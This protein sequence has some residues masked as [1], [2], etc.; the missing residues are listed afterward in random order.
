MR[1]RAAT[2]ADAAVIAAA[3]REIARVPG[4]LASRPEEITDG[5][6]A[7][8]I[9][10]V[11]KF[12][13]AERDGVI[14]GHAF[15]EPLQLAVTA[16]VVRL[17]IAV[18]PGFERQGIGRALMA[19]LVAWARASTEIEK[20]ELQVR[21]SNDA[22]IALYAAFGFVEEGRKTR[23]IKLGEGQ[24]VDDVYMALWVA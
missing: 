15:L 12:V 18:H 19:E 16:H 20:M 7:H 14:V 2:E 8:V 9:A 23:R 24:Y 17:T 11:E 10:G 6:I 22:A 5:G 21:A 3:E 4:R 1:L 13:V